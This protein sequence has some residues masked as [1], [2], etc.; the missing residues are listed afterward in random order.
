MSQNNN[1]T[2]NPNS[3]DPRQRGLQN[4]TVGYEPSAVTWSLTADEIQDFMMKYARD[5]GFTPAGCRVKLIRRAG[6]QRVQVG[7]LFNRND[8]NFMGR[9]QS[10]IPSHLRDMM[11]ESG[12]EISDEISAFLAM[13]SYDGEPHVYSNK[14]FM[15]ATLDI[16]ACIGALLDAHPMVHNLNI[17]KVYESKRGHNVTI[18]VTKTYASNNGNNNNNNNRG[19]DPLL[20]AMK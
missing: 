14:G 4:T 18:V 8:K 7:L 20:A 17:E 6:Q 16:F 11:E 10:N 12:Y 5:A 13:F 19:G 2:I 3:K 1:R 9:Q 15:V